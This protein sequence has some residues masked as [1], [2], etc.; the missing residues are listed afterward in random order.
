MQVM[1]TYFIDLLRR[2]NHGKAYAEI[3]AYGVWHIIL[4]APRNSCRVRARLGGVRSANTPH[5]LH[6]NRESEG[7]GCGQHIVGF[8]FFAQAERMLCITAG[9]RIELALSLGSLHL[10]PSHSL[11]PPPSLPPSLPA[12]HTRARSLSLSFAGSLAPSNPF[13]SFP[14]SPLPFSPSPLSLSLPRARAHPHTHTPS[15]SPSRA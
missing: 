15:L 5:I 4:P 6:E 2:S 10:P 13:S 1:A 14:F 12:S 8:V 9:H 3:L 7:E 11:P